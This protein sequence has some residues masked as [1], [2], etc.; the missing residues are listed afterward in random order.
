[1]SN[2]DTP[3]GGLELPNR[4]TTRRSVVAGILALGVGGLSVSGARDLLEMAAPLSGRVWD[5]ANRSPPET[6]ESPYGEATIDLDEN[7]V[8]HIQADDEQ[9][10]YFAVGYTQA[11][12]RLFQME[13][14]RRQM[15]GELSEV[16]GPS[17]LE[18]D[19][20]HVQMDF[21][22]AAEATVE[23][24][25]GT[26]LYGLSE[27]Y[28]DGVN[29]VI[30]NEP[31]PLEFQVLDFEPDAWTLTD[32]LLMEKQISWSLTGSFE[33]LQW[34]AVFDTLDPE[35]IRTLWPLQEDHDY[36]ILRESVDPE[37]V[38]DDE[39][40]VPNPE[41]GMGQPR[42]DPALGKYLGQF[43]SPPHVGSNSWVIN[44]EHTGGAP[45]V[46]NDPHLTLMAPP[47]WYEQHIDV[48]DYSV[49]GVTFPGVPF[50]IIGANENG[51]WGFTNV[52]GD[53]VD[54]YTYE[55]D[56]EEYNHD[57]E[58]REFDSEERTIRVSGAENETVQ[59]RK[60]VHGPYLERKGEEVGVAWTG[61]TATRTVEAVHE[62]CRSES[63]DDILEHA[64][65]FDIPTQNMVYADDETT[66]YCMVGKL[67]D[68]GLEDSVV[69][70]RRVWDG[71]A[72]EGEWGD[73]YTPYGESSW[74]GFVPFDEKPH[75]VGAE[76]VGT[77]NQRL[78]DNPAHYIGVGYSSVDRGKRVYDYLDAAAEDGGTMDVEF[79]RKMQTDL[80]DGRAAWFV[81]DL[82]VA[83]A[84][85]DVSET[86]QAAAD[87]L[88]A[89]NREMHADERAPLLFDWWL[90]RYESRVVDPLVE[91]L[92]RPPGVNGSVIAGLDPN[93]VAFEGRSRDELMVAALE[94]TVSAIDEEG[95]EVWGDEHTTGS[96]EHPFGVELGFL[97]YA[98]EP[99]D[100][101]GS[102]LRC[103]SSGVGSSWRQIVQIG[104]ESLG[105]LPG[106]NSGDWFSEH[107]QDQL[108]R[109]EAGEYK[110]MAREIA[111]TRRIDFVGESQ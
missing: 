94:E 109:W 64:E 54:V 34:P 36:P 2:D 22:S 98:D 53:V 96:I 26:Q 55:T 12:D 21:V 9:A 1:M 73:G 41:D 24:Y 95:L 65:K 99:A 52:G 23:A 46:C 81:D 42:L 75:V 11:F 72:G 43:T 83:V 107:Y 93:G 63:V 60:T 18:D 28:R 5:G 10:A 33:E 77:A 76:Y 25:E 80:V 66:L 27:A 78:V 50:V 40:G 6:V 16:V 92:E 70:D 8:P 39:V 15:R 103:F 45:I 82:V 58:W 35:L 105:I 31:L 104:G 17:T 106:G 79:C 102:T 74:E 68:R 51:A 91:D 32:S 30:E 108:M 47:V 62:F 61:M 44:S 3:L 48:P 88:E 87:E 84:D 37:G 49:R 7:G 110:T 71:S 14:I 20:F 111:G 57:G 29:A 85:A 97:N 90:D 89:W 67:P 69:P 100:G 86:V 19:R 38:A 4:T 59:V 101:S 13:L 56:G